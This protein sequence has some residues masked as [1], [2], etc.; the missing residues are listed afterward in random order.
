MP[1]VVWSWP[2]G[3]HLPGHYPGNPGRAGVNA[4]GSAGGP[5]VYLDLRHMGR[6]KL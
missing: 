2:Q 1:P 4:D 3:H 6:E 5:Y